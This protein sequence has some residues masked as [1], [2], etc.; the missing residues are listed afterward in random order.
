MK[1]A[2]LG[3]SPLALEAALRFHFHGAALT[4]YIDSDHSSLFESASYPESSFTSH[5]GLKVLDEIH[6]KYTPITFSWS[7]WS[8]HYEKPLI[9]YL[10]VHQE[11]KTDEII[12]VSKRFLAPE[13][14]IAGRSRFLDLFRIIYKVN[15]HEFIEAQKESNP[16]TYKKLTEEFV[17][18]LA[19]S[20]EMYQDYDLVLDFRSDLSWSSASVSGRALGEGRSSE[21]VAYALEYLKKSKDIRESSEFRDIADRKSV[22]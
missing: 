5:L 19:T 1:L 4:W 22:V 3:H 8:E 10:S 12:S 14:T 21:S 2:I 18:S 20:I 9:N 6:L 11:V 13:E 7:D 15:P 17:N 16:E